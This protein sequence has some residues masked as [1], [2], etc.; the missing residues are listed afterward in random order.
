VLRLRRKAGA[1]TGLTQDERLEY[2]EAIAKMTGEADDL[3]AERD[4][5]SDRA[6]RAP[7]HGRRGHRETGKVGWPRLRLRDRKGGDMQEWPSDL[8]VR[9]FPT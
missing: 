2:G 9:E 5:V 8:M 3:E 7:R 4:R 1:K 6:D